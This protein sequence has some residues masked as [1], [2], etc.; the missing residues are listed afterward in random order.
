VQLGYIST[1]LGHA[2]AQTT[3]KHYARWAGGDLYRTPLWLEPGEVPA[4]LLARL[5][6]W[7]QSGHSSGEGVAGAPDEA[8]EDRELVWFPG[9]DSNHHSQVQ[10]LLSCR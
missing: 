1:Q 10:S 2:D 5:E 7:S 4:D 8:V 9:M 3:A 6:D